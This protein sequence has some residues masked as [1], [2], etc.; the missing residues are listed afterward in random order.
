MTAITDGFLFLLLETLSLRVDG[1]LYFGTVA[2]FSFELVE[3]LF[4]FLDHQQRLVAFSLEPFNLGSC[5]GSIR[6]RCNS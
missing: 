1:G 5:V 4:H 2:H 3:A 6:V